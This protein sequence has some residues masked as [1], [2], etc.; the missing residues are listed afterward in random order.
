[1]LSLESASEQPV[2]SASSAPLRAWLLLLQG[3]R[4]GGLPPLQLEVLSVSAVSTPGVS[5]VRREMLTGLGQNVTYS[6]KRGFG[7]AHVWQVWT[8]R[9]L[10]ARLQAVLSPVVQESLGRRGHT[11]KRGAFGLLLAGHPS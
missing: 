8:H 7:I 9:L 10:P 6:K 4:L 1:M 5:R 2:I 11:D 3:G